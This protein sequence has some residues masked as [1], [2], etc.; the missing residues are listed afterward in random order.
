M[1]RPAFSSRFTFP[2]K[3]K[4]GLQ[5]VQY[6]ATVPV[7]VDRVLQART[8]N[9]L[10]PERAARFEPR[11]YGFRPGRGCHDAI[12]AIYLT[13]KGRSP[14]R[15]WILDADLAAA[16]DRIRHDDILAMLGAF[17]ARGMC[18]VVDPFRP[19]SH[20]RRNGSWQPLA[21]SRHS[22]R[23]PDADPALSMFPVPMSRRGVV[24]D[25]FAAIK[26][27]GLATSSQLVP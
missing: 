24:F 26:Q 14:R 11:S 12:A 20:I 21:H 13:G 7:I 1:P 10:E 8:L 3:P 19:T 17:P 16:F 4:S 2:P 23:D 18:E 15:R 9:A 25:S 22:G 6:E 27:R 5:E